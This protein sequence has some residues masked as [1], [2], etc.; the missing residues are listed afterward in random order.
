MDKQSGRKEKKKVTNSVLECRLKDCT[1]SLTKEVGLNVVYKDFE[2]LY[3][4]HRR[5]IFFQSDFFFLSTF[6]LEKQEA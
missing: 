6:L 5:G 2:C 4:Y 3:G 1:C